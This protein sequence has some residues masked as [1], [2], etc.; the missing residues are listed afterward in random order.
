MATVDRAA[1]WIEAARPTPTPGRKRTRSSSGT[2]SSLPPCEAA[3]GFALAFE[4]FGSAPRSIAGWAGETAPREP[5]MPIKT[6]RRVICAGNRMLQGRFRIILVR[7][8]LY[9][10]GLITSPVVLQH[11]PL[12]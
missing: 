11:T 4:V 2:Y 7:I 5:A 8:G 12:D 1:A 3:N 9:P 10:V 6:A